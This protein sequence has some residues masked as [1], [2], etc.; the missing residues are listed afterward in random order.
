MAEEKKSE[1]KH[2]RKAKKILLKGRTG[3]GEENTKIHDVSEVE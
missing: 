1:N 2:E 3:G